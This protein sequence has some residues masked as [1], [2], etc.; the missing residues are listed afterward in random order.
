MVDVGKMMELSSLC[1]AELRIDGDQAA[2]LATAR[3]LRRLEITDA[4]LG[5]GAVK[6]IATLNALHLLSLAGTDIADR[7]AGELRCSRR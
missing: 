1:M 2:Q 6:H 5:R 3:S 4:K 7:G